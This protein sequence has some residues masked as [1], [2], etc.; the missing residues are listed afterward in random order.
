MDIRR[1]GLPFAGDGQIPQ[2]IV[3]LRLGGVSWAQYAMLAQRQ[4]YSSEIGDLI[5]GG[6][7]IEIAKRRVAGNDKTIRPVARPSR[8][9]RVRSVSQFAENNVIGRG[10]SSGH[11]WLPI[12]Q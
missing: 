10:Q 7:D 4:R 11:I 12:R 6:T 3:T 2:A 1:S 5:F 9:Y 8:R